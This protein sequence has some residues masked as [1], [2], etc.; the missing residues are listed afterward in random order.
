MLDVKPERTMFDMI[1]D[2]D[3]IERD[4]ITR[5]VTKHELT[6]LDILAGPTVLEWR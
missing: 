4:D 1:R 3:M 6:D 2:M 5:Y